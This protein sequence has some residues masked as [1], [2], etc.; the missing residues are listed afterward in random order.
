MNGLRC[1]MLLFSACCER[2]IMALRCWM[3]VTG[4]LLFEDNSRMI[5]FLVFVFCVLV[6]LFSMLKV[7]L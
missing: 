5:R 7:V 3:L 4:L 2:K 6:V 1:Y